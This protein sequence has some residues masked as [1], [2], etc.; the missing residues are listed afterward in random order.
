MGVVLWPAP[1]QTQPK[2]LEKLRDRYKQLAERIKQLEARAKQK[3]RKLET[4]RKVLLGALL[5][6]WM[7]E[8]AALNQR[9]L[10]ALPEFLT[11][12]VDRDV[13]GFQPLVVETASSD[14][15]A[16]S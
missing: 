6:T 11:R 14:D 2:S 13:F 15:Q 16:T 8:D 4:R 10:K 7:D 3:D 5:A 12:Q 1:M 9:V